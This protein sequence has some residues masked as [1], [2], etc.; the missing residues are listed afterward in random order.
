MNVL[1]LIAATIVALGAGTQVQAASIDTLGSWDGTREV[2]AFGS[3]FSGV[4]GETFTAPGGD[5]TSFTFEVTTTGPLNVV[6]QVYAWS[7][8]L[9]GDSSAGAVGPAL[10]TSAPFILSSPDNYQALTINT[11]SVAMT[12]GGQYVALLADTGGNVVT[13]SDGNPVPDSAGA[14]FGQAFVGPHAGV[15]NAPGDGGFAFYN[16]GNVLGLIGANAWGDGFDLGSLAW[17]ANFN[18]PEPASMAVLGAGLF[19]LGVIRRRNAA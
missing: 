17:Q 15:P 7:G 10:F 9:Y 2:D 11:G 4:Y 3:T 18:V 16:N 14:S 13:D 19:G 1:R 12:A 5:L 8:G 6:G